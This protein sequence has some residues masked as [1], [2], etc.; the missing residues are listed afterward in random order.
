MRLKMK[1]LVLI[2]QLKP[3]DYKINDIKNKIPNITNLPTTTALTAVKNK[4]HGHSKYITAQEF[5]KLA[6]K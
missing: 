6:A 3:L 4:I 2:T 5:N 1:Y